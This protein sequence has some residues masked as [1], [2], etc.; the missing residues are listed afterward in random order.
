VIANHAAGR[1]SSE[2]GIR[3]ESLDEVLQGAMGRVRSVI[4]KLVGCQGI[5]QR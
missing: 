4:E 5:C 2:H 3:F 1:G